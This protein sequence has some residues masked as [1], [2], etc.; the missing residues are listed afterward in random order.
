[1]TMQENIK[2][3]IQKEEEYYEFNQYYNKNKMIFMHSFH[4]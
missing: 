4:I 1:M 3:M 2:F